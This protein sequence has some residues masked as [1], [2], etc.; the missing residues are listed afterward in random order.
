VL[1]NRLRQRPSVDALERALL[2]EHMVEVERRTYRRDE[3]SSEKTAWEAS[4]RYDIVKAMPREGRAIG[5]VVVDLAGF[6][7]APNLYEMAR[8]GEVSRRWLSRQLDEICCELVPDNR[9]A[10]MRMG[11]A[12]FQHPLMTGKLPKSRVEPPEGLEPAGFK[13]N[14]PWRQSLRG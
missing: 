12:V 6:C 2:G 3:A 9:P 10:G 5:E 11:R 14:V 1:L 4:G 13:H 7:R 8:D